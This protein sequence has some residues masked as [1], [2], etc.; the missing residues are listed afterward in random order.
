MTQTAILWPNDRPC[1]ARL[2][3]SMCFSGCARRQAVMAG[4]AKI[5]RLQGK[6]ERA[7]PEAS[8]RRNK[9]RKPVRTAKM[10]F[11]AACPGALR[12]GCG[13]ARVAVALAWLFV[14]S[15]IVHTIK[16]TSPRT[17]SATAS[18]HS[19]RASCYSAPCGCCS[20]STSP[21]A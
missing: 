16:S 21:P 14:A 13:P 20:P 1:R 6:P 17:A 19:W 7:A 2:S 5:F 3:P 12:V 10:L 9:S 15:R 11:H 8:L 18:R 4:E